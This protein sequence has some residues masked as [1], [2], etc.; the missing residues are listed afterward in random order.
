MTTAHRPTWKPSFGLSDSVNKGY[1]PTRAYSA[2]VPY[3]PLRIFPATSNSRTENWG[4]ALWTNSN[5][6][7]SKVIFC[8]DRPL[9]NERKMEI[10]K[11]YKTQNTTKIVFTMM[12]W[13][14][15][16]TTNPRQGRNW[17]KTKSWLTW[18]TIP[19]LKMQIPNLSSTPIVKNRSGRN[20]ESTH[21][22]RT[23]TPTTVQN[24]WRNTKG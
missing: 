24:F 14:W 11:L 23:M 2:R 5:K 21:S 12:K 22:L 6:K 8:R 15:S 18:P 4:R 19:S 13:M 20:P 10:L 3:Q 9:P 17:R 16:A 1:V 7:I